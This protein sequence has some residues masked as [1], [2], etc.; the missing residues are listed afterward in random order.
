M[1]TEN[2]VRQTS[3]TLCLL[4]ILAR[5]LVR[6]ALWLRLYAFYSVDVLRMTR[7]G[8]VVVIVAT[9]VVGRGTGAMSATR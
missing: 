1:F 3:N 8:C 7:R 9:M 5:R 2:H 4:F 6:I